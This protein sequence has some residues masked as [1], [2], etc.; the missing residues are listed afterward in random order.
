MKYLN[1]SLMWHIASQV[2][3]L[4][5]LVVLNKDVLVGLRSNYDKPEQMKELFRRL[6]RPKISQNVDSVLQRMSIIGVIICFRS[7]AQDALNDCLSERIPFLLSSI[8]DFKHHVMNG[9]SM[10][11]NIKLQIVSEMAS[12]TGLPCKV[13]PALVSALRSQKCE[14]GEDEYQMACLLMVFIAVSLPKLARNESSYYK[15]SLEA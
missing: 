11:E 9:D 5:K 8:V 15:P 1:E 10:L 14:L 12:A 4:K 3:E 2:T 13:D 7:L 6:Q